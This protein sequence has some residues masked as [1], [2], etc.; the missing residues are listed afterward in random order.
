ME[1]SNDIIDTNQINTSNKLPTFLKVLCI[2]TFIGSGLGI[3]SALINFTTS[4]LTEESLNLSNKVLQ[5][6]P[7]DGAINIEEMINWQKYINLSNLIGSLLCLGGALL[8]WNLKKVGYYLYIPGW[9]IPITVSAIGMKYMISG[10]LAGFGYISVVLNVIFAA[11]FITMYGL[12]FKH[13]K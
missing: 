7:F 8:M 6:S 3:L 12:N 13:L 2:L 10:S 9:I 11:A 5:G 1:T 4:D